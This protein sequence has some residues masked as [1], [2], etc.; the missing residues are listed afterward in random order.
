MNWLTNKMFTSFVFLREQK[1]YGARSVVYKLK[2]SLLRK[3]RTEEFIDV[4]REVGLTD[5]A[6]KMVEGKSDLSV[7]YF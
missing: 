3:G 1:N 5:L 4:L 2:G 7:M 6:D